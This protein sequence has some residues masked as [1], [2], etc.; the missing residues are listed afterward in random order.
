MPPRP[1]VVVITRRAAEGSR[2]RAIR[3]KL[4]ASH[5]ERSDCKNAP[6]CFAAVL[7]SSNSWKYL[8]S[9]HIGPPAAIEFKEIV[10]GKRCAAPTFHG[11]D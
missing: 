2:S 6:E 9:L 1:S 5:K 11:V 10:D 3:A 8:P 4:R 7:P